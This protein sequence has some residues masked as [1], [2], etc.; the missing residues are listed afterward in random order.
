[1]WR[2]MF[3]IT[4]IASSTTNPLA[5][6]S[7]ISDRLSSEKPHKYITAHVPISE[8]GTATAGISVAGILRRKRNTTRITSTTEMISVLSIS[9]TEALIVSVRS[10]I[11]KMCMPAGIEACSE[12]I[13]A[14]IA[15]T[16]VMMLAPGCRK[17]I[18]STDGLPFRYP[19]C[20]T[21]CCESITSATS[22]SRTAPPL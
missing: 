10:R 9:C 22:C 14:L 7:A 13:A 18:K 4:T 2:E 8:T 1:M 21:D 11:V 19:A 15:S 12:G 20:R 6:A 16:V 3:S 5:I 17:M